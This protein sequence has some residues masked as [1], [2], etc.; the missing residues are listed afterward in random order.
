MEYYRAS[1]SFGSNGLKSLVVNLNGATP[2][3]YRITAGARLNTT[4]AQPIFA[5]GGSDGTRKHCFAHAPGVSK[6]W[7]YAG[8][9]DYVIAH[10]NTVGA[11]VLSATH[12]SVG[13][14]LVKINFDA[15]NANYP[16]VV[17][18]WA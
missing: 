11:K 8:E 15:S 17:E 1:F 9:P 16:L 14:D 6:R 3:G 2:K 7:P 10:Y 4:E 18:A 13:P 5:Q 12:D